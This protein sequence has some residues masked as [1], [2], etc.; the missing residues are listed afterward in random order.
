MSIPISQYI[1]LPFFLTLIS[2]HLFSASVSLFLS[3]KY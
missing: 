3:S 2:I 1:P